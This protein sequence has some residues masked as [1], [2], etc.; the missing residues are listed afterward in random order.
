[1]K[2][3]GLILFVILL[4]FQAQ[5]Q[6]AVA[7]HQSNLPM[8]EGTY[9]FEN[10]INAH[11]R[12]ASDVSFNDFS[13]EIAGSYNFVEKEDLNFYG[14]LGF[15]FNAFES[16]VLPVG[17]QF[18]PFAEKRFGFHIEAAALIATGSNFNPDVF[19]GSWGIRYRFN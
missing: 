9:T 2:K 19:R 15:R 17:V 10:K 11:L 13:P 4:S 18:Y 5:A 12:F 6:F 7:F 14:G 1:M 8:I 3:I 16:V